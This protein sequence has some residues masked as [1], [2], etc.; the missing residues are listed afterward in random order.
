MNGLV[1][2]AIVFI[3]ISIVP[4]GVLSG[5]IFS[6]GGYSK[7]EITVAPNNTD[8]IHMQ[9]MGDLMFYYDVDT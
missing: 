2:V 4:V 9:V 7:H 6:E 8:V 1:V 5:V 3:S